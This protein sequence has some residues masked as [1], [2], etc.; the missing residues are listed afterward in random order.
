[1]ANSDYLFEVSSS[2]A[3][4]PQ[5]QFVA[6]LTLSGS[7]TVLQRIKQQ[8]NPSSFGVFDFGQIVASII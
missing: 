7:S 2:Q 5:F 8:P 1:M 4:Q 3:S 6:D